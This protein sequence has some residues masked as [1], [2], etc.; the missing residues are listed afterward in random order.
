MKNMK[1]SKKLILSFLVAIVFAGAAGVV[2]LFG[3]AYLKAAENRLFNEGMEGSIAAAGLYAVSVEERLELGGIL[4]EFGKPKDAALR[5]EALRT[6]EADF[7][8]L[9]DKLLTAMPTATDNPILKEAMDAYNGEYKTHKEEVVSFL[10]VR[11][12]IN[13]SIA[14][15]ASLESGS[16]VTAHMYELMTEIEGQ[17]AAMNAAD[18]RLSDTRMI[19]QV[20]V[21]ASCVVFTMALAMYLSRQISRP[22]VTLTA[23]MKRAGTDGDVTPSADDQKIVAAFG[24]NKDELGQ[25]VSASTTFFARINE[26]STLLETLSGGDLR[27]D[28]SP[29]S[30]RDVLG[31]SLEKLSDSLNQMIGN[32][33]YSAIQVSTGATQVSE[34]AQ[35]LAQ[36]AT[37]QAATVEELSSSMSEVAQRTKAN[38]LLAEKAARLAESI[39]GNA[40]KGSGQ[41]QEMIA[42]VREINK[43]S[44]D[45]SKIIKVI[46]DIAFQTN[47]LALNASV[48][49]ARAGQHGKGFAVVAQEVRNLA[50]KSADAAKDTG[51]LIAKSME[52]AESGVRIAD[53]TS[54]SLSEIVTGI[55]ESSQLVSEIAGGSEEQSHAIG[56]I[57]NSIE[58]VAKVV[59]QNSATAEESAAA[60]QE[61][62][63]Q[64]LLLQELLTQFKIR[65]GSDSLSIA[66]GFGVE[67]LEAGIDFSTPDGSPRFG[68]Y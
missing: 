26:I 59:Q 16:V 32:I 64:S 8:T 11:D 66:A 17:A 9:L 60:S 63:S 34:G 46:D 27:I 3:I 20:V 50:A 58:Q 67:R 7:Q 49:A 15:E 41:M 30:E 6:R 28:I 48:E 47:I 55:N 24:S 40:E 43:S 12:Y 25:L 10:E 65:E 37:E 42:A 57:N 33:N 62:N 53:G 22:L 5:V 29:L 54:S 21:M 35:N 4:N 38:A 19:V 51:D 18:N 44:N 52:K 2:G 39:R 1:V 36:G 56:L 23:F 68:K 61:M 13:L 14:Y 31:L 45:I